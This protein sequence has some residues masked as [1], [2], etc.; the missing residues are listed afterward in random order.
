VTDGP[1]IERVQRLVAVLV[2]VG[3]VRVNASAFALVS[4]ARQS[5]Y[6]TKANRHERDHDGLAVRRSIDY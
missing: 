6:G 1:A 3:G 5:A 4:K 2:A